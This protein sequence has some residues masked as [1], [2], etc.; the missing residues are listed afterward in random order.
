L[1]EAQYSAFANPEI[2]KPYINFGD[3]K[4]TGVDL[5]LNYRDSKG[6][7]SWDVSL[8]LSHYKNEVLRISESDD[9]S[10]WG[11]GTRLDGNV[12]RTT[13]GHAISEFY[14][15]KVNGFYEN[16]DEVLALPPLGQSGL[17]AE[18]A[19]AWVGK[20][21]FDDVDKDGKLTERDRTFIG[22]PHPDLIAGLNA[23]VTWKNW[24][25]TMFWYSTIGN[26]LFNNTKYFTDFWM[27]NGN[28][29]E[30]MR[31]QSWTPG[32]DNSNA[33][34]PILDSNDGYSGKFSN[35]Y[36]VENA[37]FLRLKNVV[38][39]YTLPKSVLSKVGI[40]NLRLYVQAENLLTITGYSGLDPEYTNADMGKESGGDL[41]R[42]VDMGGWPST[43]RFLFGVNFAF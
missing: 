20:F 26:D 14:G 34:L 23:T 40:Q 24:D 27:F 13:K 9:A 32:A 17:N 18:S 19:K 8:N 33:I 36:Y 41:Q 37:S 28:K 4:N 2:K 39:G 25:F 16:V 1:I 38:L 5:N 10:L 22:S 21:K 30:R 31:D 29:S 43:M 12:T 6:D 42:G 7:W 15:Y 3:I 11:A 35:S